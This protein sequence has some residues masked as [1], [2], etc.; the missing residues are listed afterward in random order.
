[1]DTSKIDLKI[2]KS[3]EDL[4]KNYPIVNSLSKDCPEKVK[5]WYILGYYQAIKEVLLNGL[6]RS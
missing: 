4:L 3:W 2:D 1:M 6:P 5:N